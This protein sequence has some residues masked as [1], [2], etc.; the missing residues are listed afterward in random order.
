MRTD[1]IFTEETEKEREFILGE[2]NPIRAKTVLKAARETSSKPLNEYSFE[3][4]LRL[5]SSF[6]TTSVSVA[7]GYVSIIKRFLAFCGED[8]YAWSE[9]GIS[10]IRDIIDR[11]DVLVKYFNFGQIERIVSEIPNYRDKFIVLGSYE[12]LAGRFREELWNVRINDFDESNLTLRCYSG[13]TKSVSQELMY[14]AKKSAETYVL[15]SYNRSDQ[16]QDPDPWGKYV[17]KFA[18]RR[19]FNPSPA[20]RQQQIRK[21]LDR[22]GEQLGEMGMTW[23]NLHYS[24][25]MYQMQKIM[26]KYDCSFHEALSR[27]ETDFI[28]NQYDLEQTEN[29]FLLAMARNSFI[30]SNVGARG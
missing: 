15:Y 11:D 30:I 25:F 13:K 17:V 3:E 23:T 10:D 9:V 26:L 4:C 19:S 5:L 28:K 14:Y 1:V 24:G 12:G 27:Q 20:A 21:R 7:A 8:S 22:L 29:K 18:K 6:H 16:L 2:S